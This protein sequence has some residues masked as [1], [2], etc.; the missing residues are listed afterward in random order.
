[1]AGSPV[2]GGPRFWSHA[3]KNV[4]ALVIAAVFTV[5]SAAAGAQSIAPSKVPEEMRTKQQNYLLP[6]QAQQFIKA[7]KGKVLFVDVRTRAEA[8]FLGIDEL[9]L[10]EYE[11]MLEDRFGLAATGNCGG[12]P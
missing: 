8:Q 5:L 7:Q 10:A 6:K 1:M 9:S 2:H 4:L 3:V 12:A 11:I